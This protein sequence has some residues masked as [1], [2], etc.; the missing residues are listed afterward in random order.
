M[1]G[2][3]KLRMC[4]L[5][6]GEMCGRR[7]NSRWNFSSWL[8]AGKH[9]VAVHATVIAIRLLV[10]GGLTWGNR[11]HVVLGRGRRVVV[12]V[13]AKRI[14]KVEVARSLHPGV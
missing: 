11:C 12:F 14:E 5:E 2:A 10:G 8:R 7:K 6:F 3:R 1:R 13:V 9:P 4:N